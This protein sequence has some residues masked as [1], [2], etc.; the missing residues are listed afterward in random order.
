MVFKYIQ[1]VE[2]KG[3]RMRKVSW[4]RAIPIKELKKG[5]ESDYHYWKGTPQPRFGH[6]CVPIADS[7]FLIAWGGNAGIFSDLCVCDI[8]NSLFFLI[9][10]VI[11]G[12]S[13][14]PFFFF[15]F[16]LFQNYEKIDNGTWT[17]LKAV[18]EEPTPSA[19]FGMETFDI[20]QEVVVV[21][22]FGGVV[23]LEDKDVFSNRVFLSFSLVLIILFLS[24]LLT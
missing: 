12:Y 21:Y 22:F 19:S 20:G 2:R 9:F 3:K 7:K 11:I 4:T 1:Q 5:K 6:R 23:E 8:G 15:F 10:L 16:I 24:F 17:T 14:S 13:Y 18:G